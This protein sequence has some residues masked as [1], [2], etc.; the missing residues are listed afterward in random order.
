MNI[1]IPEGALDTPFRRNKYICDHI[2]VAYSASCNLFKIGITKEPVKRISVMR[3]TGYGGA[4]DWEFH[5][6][7]KVG[8][9]IAHKYEVEIT[10]QLYSFN[11]REKYL[12]H[13]I[14]EFG[15]ELFNCDIKIIKAAFKT[16]GLTIPVTSPALRKRFT[17]FVP[18]MNFLN[19]VNL[20]RKNYGL[21]PMTIKELEESKYY[22][23]PQSANFS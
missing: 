4:R 8:I 17:P 21:N 14:S 19:W 1:D 6:A 2:Y 23:I 15:K 13:S 10:R 18:K 11:I 22:T 5:Y 7:R 20:H 12:N 9:K 16:V 3:S